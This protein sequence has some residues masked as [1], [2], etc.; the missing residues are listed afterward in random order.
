MQLKTQT[1]Y[2]VRTL[3]YLAGKHDWT[4]IKET[5][6][7]VGVAESYL[8]RVVKLLRGAGWVTTSAGA[9]GGMRLVGKTELISLLDVMQVTENAMQICRCME[10][11]AYCRWYQDGSCPVYGTYTLFQNV[12]ERY[13]ASITIADLLEPDKDGQL[14]SKLRNVLRGTS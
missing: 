5:A 14:E 13:F 6:S 3:I 11:Q 7:S 10:D 2:A 12:M 4:S 8:P 9:T 1:E